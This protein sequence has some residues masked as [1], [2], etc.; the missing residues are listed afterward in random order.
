MVTVQDGIDDLWNCQGV[1]EVYDRL[2]SLHQVLLT[3]RVGFDPSEAFLA[4]QGASL[5][6]LPSLKNQQRQWQEEFK[7][8]QAITQPADNQKANDGVKGDESKIDA[9][10]EEKEKIERL[11]W[12]VTEESLWA[13]A[14]LACVCV[15]PAW[16]AQTQKRKQSLAQKRGEDE[17]SVKSSA[18]FYPPD[19]L[20]LGNTRSFSPGFT[21]VSALSTGQTIT[22]SK[23]IKYP[24]IPEVLPAAMLRFAASVL[25]LIPDRDV[26]SSMKE[27]ERDLWKERKKKIAIGQR[28]LVLALCCES[29]IINSNTAQEEEQSQHLGPKSTEWTIPGANELVG[30]MLY[31]WLKVACPLDDGHRRPMKK[32]VDDIKVDQEESEKEYIEDWWYTLGVTRATTDLVSTGWRPLSRSNLGFIMVKH[33]LEIA[34]TGI[35]LLDT[36]SC[37]RDQKSTSE[38]KPKEERLAAS[39]SAAEAISALASLGSR[40][41]IPAESQRITTRKICR[42][43]VISGLIKASI[44]GVFPLGSRQNEK[45]RVSESERKIFLTQI[46]SCFADTTDFLWILFSTQTSSANAIRALLDTVNAADPS[47]PVCLLFSNNGWDSDKKLICMEAGTAVRM[48]SAAI[49][50]RPPG[51]MNTAHLRAYMDDILNTIRGI[52]FS[53]HSHVHG[54]LDTGDFI[55]PSTC[56]FLSLLLDSVVA[57]GSFADRQLVG[58]ADLVSSVEWDVFLHALEEAFVPWLDYSNFNSTMD[59]T[60]NGNEV[61]KVL[62]SILERAHLELQSLLLRVGA[63]LDKYV[64]IEGSPFHSIVSYSSQRKLY[65]FILN[66][67]IPHMDPTDAELLGLSVAR[68]WAKFGLYPFRVDDLAQTTSEI[69]SQTFSIYESALSVLLTTCFLQ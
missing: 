23:N 38:T 67:A 27:K 61:A 64:R 2:K 8:E 46:E 36:H 56:D 14:A 20:Q 68:A 40:G 52:S 5:R 12:S 48:V 63:F 24:S 41:L 39:S 30:D 32:T 54:R 51:A 10:R 15:G 33:L 29:P 18:S 6:F 28:Y 45:Q 42:L 4:I 31:F 26:F 69:L 43:H 16:R 7:K 22:R 62:P 44:A 1:K 49:W 9:E 3:D 57:L 17:N 58:G 19:E 66:T 25:T 13:A 65:L 59:A 50:G 35:S 21:A 60:S 11:H 37:L 53:L 47:S 55:V 34:E